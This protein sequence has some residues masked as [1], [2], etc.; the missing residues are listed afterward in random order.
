MKL[1]SIGILVLVLTAQAA[2]QDKAKPTQEQAIAAI[3]K[4]GGS[5]CSSVVD[6][7]SFAAMRG[8][9]IFPLH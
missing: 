4:L 2:A 6:V 1:Q 7:S 3:K 9:W 8:R 5:P